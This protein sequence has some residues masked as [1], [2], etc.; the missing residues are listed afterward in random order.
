MQLIDSRGFINLSL[1]DIA[2]AIGIKREGVYYYYKNR[3]DILLAIIQ[4]TAED[5]VRGL[6]AILRK[7]ADPRKRLQ[8]AIENHLMRLERAHLVTRITLRDTYFQ[9]ARR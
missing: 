4:P 1:G 2:D 9:E 5:L 3:F 7:D 8:L 6:K